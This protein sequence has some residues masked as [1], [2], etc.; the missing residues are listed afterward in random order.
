MS[1]IGAIAL[2]YGLIWAII[3]GYALFISRRQHSL[4]RQLEQLR[5]EVDEAASK[6]ASNS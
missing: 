5:L 4:K 1:T 3:G 6:G 2:A